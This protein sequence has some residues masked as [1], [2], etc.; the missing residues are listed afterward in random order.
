MCALGFESRK[1]IGVETTWVTWKIQTSCCG[2]R[3]VHHQRKINHKN[4][5]FFFNLYGWPGG[6]QLSIPTNTTLNKHYS[7]SVNYFWIF[8]IFFLYHL[9]LSFSRWSHWYMKDK[10]V[11]FKI[12]IIWI[13]FINFALKFRSVVIN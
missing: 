10:I 3:K 7:K 4:C 11:A 8:N 13:F 12:N 6:Q 9:M 5:K 1:Y 2:R